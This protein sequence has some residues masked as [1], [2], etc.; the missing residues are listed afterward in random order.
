MSSYVPL[1]TIYMNRNCT[2]CGDHGASVH[3]LCLK[4]TAL[5]V[6]KEKQKVDPLTLV[7]TWVKRGPTHTIEHYVKELYQGTLIFACGKSVSVG[8]VAPGSG[9]NGYH[10]C[11]PCRDEIGEK[12]DDQ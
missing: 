1:I 9:L 10:Q 3:G 5:K 8:D 6:T 7:N 12:F 11:G 4:C 2:Q